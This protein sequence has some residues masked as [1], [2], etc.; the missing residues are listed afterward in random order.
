MKVLFLLGKLGKKFFFFCEKVF[1]NRLSFELLIIT[2]VLII[3]IG[4]NLFL[5]VINKRKINESKNKLE[6]KKT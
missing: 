6:N 5:F 3:K 2:N 4:D 1:L